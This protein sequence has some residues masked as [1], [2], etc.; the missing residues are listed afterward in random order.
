MPTTEGKR[1]AAVEVLLGTKT[2]QELI[3]HGRLEDIKEIMEKSENLG[4]QTIDSA[5]FKLVDEGRIGLEDALANADSENNL[6]LRIKLANGVVPG[7]EP[8]P[9]ETTEAET[10]PT[11]ASSFSQLA[12]EEIEN[13]E[14]DEEPKFTKHPICCAVESQNAQVYR[15]SQRSHQCQPRNPTRSRYLHRCHRCLKCQL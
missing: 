2:I 11:S 8:E 13:D 7:S 4:M 9:E 12:L 14:T 10:S 5:L 3:L 15:G 1:C 6:R